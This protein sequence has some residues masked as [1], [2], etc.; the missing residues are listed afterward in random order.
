MLQEIPIFYCH[1]FW[2]EHSKKSFDLAVWN[3]GEV[4]PRYLD[5]EHNEKDAKTIQ[6]VITA[7]RMYHFCHYFYQRLPQGLPLVASAFT[8]D[9]TSR[10]CG[11]TKLR[12]L[13]DKKPNSSVSLVRN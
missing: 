8:I 12:I 10:K 1:C 9:I 6:E 11:F 3:L 5:S 4:I 13:K 7:I 2:N